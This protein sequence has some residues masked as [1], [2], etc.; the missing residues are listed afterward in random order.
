MGDVGNGHDRAMIVMWSSW[1]RDDDKG[2]DD[3]NEG[4]GVESED[5]DEDGSVAKEVHTCKDAFHQQILP[6]SLPAR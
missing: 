2:A 1:L 5:Y 6:K 4:D 3:D